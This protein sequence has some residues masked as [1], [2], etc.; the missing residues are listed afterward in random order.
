MNKKAFNTF[1]ESF[2]KSFFSFIAAMPSWIN[3]KLRIHRVVKKNKKNLIPAVTHVDRSARIQTVKRNQNPLFYD[4]IKEFGRISHIPVLL[5]TSFNVRG[6]PIVCSPEDA[7]KCF[8]G[9][10]IDYL[11]LGNFLIAKENI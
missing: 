5:N 6:E 1:L 4:L 10:G 11:V 3:E 9:T 2:P 8:M 7:Y